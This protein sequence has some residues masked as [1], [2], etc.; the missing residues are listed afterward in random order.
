MV[1]P[2]TRDW[3]G[4]LVIYKF[5]SSRRGALLGVLG[6]LA[7]VGLAIPATAAAK[8][9]SL[10]S[11]QTIAAP[12]EYRLDADISVNSP[13]PA[14]CFDI[15]ASDVR[16]NLNGHT[17]T[18]PQSEAFG[19]T[20]INVEGGAANAKIVGPGTLDL[21][22]PNGISLGGGNGSV[23]G[24]TVTRDSIGIEIESSDNSVRGNLD[25]SNGFGVFG[26]DVDTGTGNT[27]IGN[28]AH[29]NSG[30]DLVDNNANCDSNVWRG[31]DFGTAFPASCIH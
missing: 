9:T 4:V 16:L 13:T 21:W 20:A 26:I 3:R 10:T 1:G 22:D 12:G 23:R 15:T 5:V 25:T 28:S 29:G 11:C 7:A 2:Y 30:F 8:V 6:C 19:S 27:I 24:V 17:I 31:N 18:G 14:D